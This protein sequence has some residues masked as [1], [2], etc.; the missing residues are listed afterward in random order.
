MVDL[1]P[2]VIS[3]VATCGRGTTQEFTPRLQRENLALCKI[4]EPTGYNT[5][6]TQPSLLST[7]TE[8]TCRNL[9]VANPTIQ[10]C[11]LHVAL[12][13]F[14]LSPT[15]PH[16]RV[17]NTACFAMFRELDSARDWER[18][19]EIL[20]RNGCSRRLADWK[21]W[22]QWTHKRLVVLGVGGFE[23]VRVHPGR[24]TW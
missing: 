1:G 13:T 7:V 23:M 8:V 22:H 24:R 12:S 10:G 18:Y 11:K 15:Q 21:R 6:I 19:T 14:I 2:V 5:A 16:G 17:T 4:V 3:N 20:L 9:G